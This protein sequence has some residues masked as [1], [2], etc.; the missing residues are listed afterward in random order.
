MAETKVEK[1]RGRQKIY[2]SQKLIADHLAVLVSA[3]EKIDAARALFD[4]LRNA[5]VP[6]ELLKE[7]NATVW[8]ALTASQKT[9]EK[10]INFLAIRV[11][12]KIRAIG[13]RDVAAM[14]EIFSNPAVMELFPIHGKESAEDFV[15]EVEVDDEGNEVEVEANAGE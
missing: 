5:G 9:A 11:A 8:D 6:D 14:V 1:K 2:A 3:S 13:S 10:E 4:K 7:V 15:G 12:E